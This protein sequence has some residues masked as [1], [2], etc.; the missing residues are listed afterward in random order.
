MVKSGFRDAYH[1]KKYI[2][3]NI[4]PWIP[5][6]RMQVRRYEKERCVWK[7]VDQLSQSKKKGISQFTSEVNGWGDW[8]V[9]CIKDLIEEPLYRNPPYKAL[10][11]STFPGDIDF[12]TTTYDE[13]LSALKRAASREGNSSNS[14]SG[15]GKKNSSSKSSHGQVMKIEVDI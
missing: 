9:L 1:M 15:S 13:Y 11:P 2:S 14:N 8:T 7:A 3:E 5:P 4:C 10:T 12:F 6:E